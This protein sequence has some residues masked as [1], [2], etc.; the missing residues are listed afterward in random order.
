MEIE[1]EFFVVGVECEG[2]ERVVVGCWGWGG[3]CVGIVGGEGWGGG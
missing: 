2:E 3:D 1:E